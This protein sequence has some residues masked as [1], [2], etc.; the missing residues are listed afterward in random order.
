MFLKFGCITLFR[1]EVVSQSVDTPLRG[2]MQ[3]LARTAECAHLVLLYW[4]DG[5]KP[6]G[7]EGPNLQDRAANANGK[8]DEPSDLAFCVW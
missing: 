1:N 3:L 8:V 5:A 6:R 7:Q 4:R 2:R